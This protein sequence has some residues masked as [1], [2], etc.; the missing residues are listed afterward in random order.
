MNEKNK[1]FKQN[2]FNNNQ[3]FET[4]FKKK[5]TLFSFYKEN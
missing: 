2:K 1:F 5:E 4:I 3:R